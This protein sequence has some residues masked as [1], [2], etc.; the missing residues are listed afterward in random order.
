MNHCKIIVW[1]HYFCND[2]SFCPCHFHSFFN[3]IWN[4]FIIV[5]FSNDILDIHVILPSIMDV[6]WMKTCNEKKMS[7]S[8]YHIIIYYWNAPSIYDY[9]FFHIGFEIIFYDYSQLCSCLE[10][11]VIVFLVAK[12]KIPFS[13]I[14][15]TKFGTWWNFCI[16]QSQKG[17]A[18]G[19]PWHNWCTKLIWN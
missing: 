17:K 14:M 6:I 18:C 10:H 2:T 3:H 12:D 7:P 9:N 19:K 8:Y 4:D 15:P 5:T 11:L 13:E 1:P 16:H